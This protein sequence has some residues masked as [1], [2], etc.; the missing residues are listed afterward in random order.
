M[1]EIEMLQAIDVLA[2]K[3]QTTL[4]MFRELAAVVR[5]VNSNLRFLADAVG[6]ELPTP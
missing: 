5:A 1:T 6:V 2:E 3:L 4:D